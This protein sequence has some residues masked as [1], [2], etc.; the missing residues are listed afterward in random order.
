MSHEIV[1]YDYIPDYGVNACID[2]EWDF[3][4]SFNELFIAC[5]ETIGDDFVLVSVALSSGSWVGYQET[6]C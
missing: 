4:S 1:Y 3:F 6:V 2:G 5:V